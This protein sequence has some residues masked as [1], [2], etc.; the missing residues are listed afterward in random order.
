MPI[1]DRHCSKKYKY[2]DEQ[3][4]QRLRG[5]ICRVI[6][7]VLTGSQMEARHNH[8]LNEWVNNLNKLEF[9]FEPKGVF[10]GQ[11]GKDSGRHWKHLC[12]GEREPKSPFDFSSL[13]RSD[14]SFSAKNPS[15]L[16]LCMGSQSHDMLMKALIFIVS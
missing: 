6:L 11:C 8:N 4:I 1:M 10:V 9:C 3:D 15:S 2:S 5:K 7:R 14:S 12:P 16:N 13:E